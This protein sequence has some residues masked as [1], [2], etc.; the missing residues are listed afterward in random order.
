MYSEICKL[1][2]TLL[3]LYL[4]FVFIIIIGTNNKSDSCCLPPPPTVISACAGASTQTPKHPH[5]RSV[6]TEIKIQAM[7]KLI[8]VAMTFALSKWRQYKQVR[9][10]RFLLLQMQTEIPQM[11]QIV[12]IDKD[13]ERKTS[14]TDKR[15]RTR[16]HSIVKI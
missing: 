4:L 14:Q 2:S 1:V 9:N 15:T 11:D 6:Y 12:E 3:S 13:D 8:F 16:I 7:I 5:Q 10:F